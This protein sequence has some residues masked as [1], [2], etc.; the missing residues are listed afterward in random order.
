MGGLADDVRPYVVVH[1]LVRDLTAHHGG[2]SFQVLKRDVARHGLGPH[3]LVVI[4]GALEKLGFVR[5]LPDGRVCACA[6]RQDDE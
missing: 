1:D 2:A 6:P 4:L 5:A 3:D